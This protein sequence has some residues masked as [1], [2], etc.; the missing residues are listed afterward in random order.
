[1]FKADINAEGVFTTPLYLA[2]Q[3][4]VVFNFGPYPHGGPTP[5]NPNTYTVATEGTKK[6]CAMEEHSKSKG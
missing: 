2:A 6:P 3:P 5:T 1:M 4:Q